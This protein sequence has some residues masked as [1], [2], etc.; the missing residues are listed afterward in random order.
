MTVREYDEHCEKVMGQFLD[1]YFY[2][3]YLDGNVTRITDKKL[4]VKGV[5]VVIDDGDVKFY[6]DEKA[7]IRYIG[8]KTFALELSF[9]NR[10]GNVNTGWLLDDTKINSHFLFV[11]INELYG[12]TIENE[13]SI[14]NV[15]VALVSRDSILNYLSSIGW[16]KDNLSLKDQ[17]IR[18][19]KNTYMGNIRKNGCK[20]AYSEQLIEKPINILLPKEKYMEMADFSV[21]IIV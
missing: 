15:D 7:A 10:Q 5:D 8:L 20:F 21:N 9:L 12:E 3:E 17:Q 4:Q 14:K 19:N 11:W 1:K 18:S 16:N 6:V 2:E 13:Q